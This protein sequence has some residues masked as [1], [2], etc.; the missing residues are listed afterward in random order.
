M[1]VLI[2]EEAYPL[3]LLENIFDDASFYNINNSF[4]GVIKTVGY[5][6]SDTR[7]TLVY[8]LPKVF[9]RDDGKTVF[10]LSKID[11]ANMHYND[12]FTFDSK[13]Q[14]V[15]QLAIYFYNSLK[16]F[17]RRHFQSKLFNKSSHT[18]L[19]SNIP[20]NEYSYLDLLLTFVNFYQLQELHLSIALDIMMVS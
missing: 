17:K 18:F 13:Y 1:Y 8:M 16:E 5:Y 15:R 10:G 4:E 11:L 12:S 6:Y 2:E 20:Q 7:G 9:M 3:D 19:N 14:W